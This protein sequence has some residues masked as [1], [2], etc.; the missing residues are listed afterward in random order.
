MPPEAWKTLPKMPNGAIGTIDRHHED[1]SVDEQVDEGQR[2]LELL[3]V[4]EGLDPG[5][6]LGGVRE[7]TGGG[8]FGH[9]WSS[10]GGARLRAGRGESRPNCFQMEANRQ[11]GNRS[12]TSRKRRLS[13]CASR[14]ATEVRR[15]GRRPALSAT[16]ARTPSYTPRA[17]AQTTGA[18]GPDR[19][20]SRSWRASW[21]SSAA[22]SAAAKE[23]MQAKSSP[24]R[25]PLS[26]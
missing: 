22:P 23:G 13:A 24:V 18:G 10:S 15:D 1:Q 2:P 14:A 17:Y 25:S 6:A 9:G 8:W 11:G 7:L 12:V 4:A 19:D 20:G 26:A 3:L 21:P 5:A 16:A